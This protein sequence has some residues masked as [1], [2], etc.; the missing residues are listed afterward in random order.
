M[1]CCREKGVLDVCL[2]YCSKENEIDHLN[3][4]LLANHDKLMNC[5]EWFKQIGQCRKGLLVY[6]SKN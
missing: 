6:T 2:G 1:K 3:T 5:E 4:D